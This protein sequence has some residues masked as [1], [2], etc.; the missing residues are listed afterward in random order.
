MKQISILTRVFALFAIIGFF[1]SCDPVEQVDPPVV[2]FGQG[3]D[4]ISSNA[5]VNSKAEF[6]VQVKASK[7]ANPMYTLTI[8][9]D[10][11]K[12]DVSRFTINGSSDNNPKLLFDSDKTS[13]TY[14]ITITA[15][16]SGDAVYDF[17]VNDEGSKSSDKGSFTI[18]IDAQSAAPTISIFG[19]ADVEIE[20]PTIWKMQVDATKGGADLATLAVYED[21]VLVDAG[22]LYYGDLNT[23]FTEN[24][25]TLPEGDVAGFMKD[26]YVKTHNTVE[27]KKYTLKLVD[28]AEAEG[29]ASVNITIKPAATA[30][31]NEWTNVKLYNNSGP[32]FGAIDLETGSNVSSSDA[33]ADIVDLGLSDSNWAKQIKPTSGTDLRALGSG[34][35]LTY[36]S[37]DSKEKLTAAF[38]AGTSLTETGTLVV[39]ST[40]T[41]K[42]NNKLYVFTVASVNETSNDNKDYFEI[43]IKEAQ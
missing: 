18:S 43:N 7:G 25:L 42:V 13:F 40:Y 9:Q 31:T 39:G 2:S 30:L 15:H 8:L 28:K 24:P 17:V 19:S 27:T 16:A 41:A 32:N 6:K 34:E 35:T 11:E 29:T 14:D 37:I 26:I 12:L 10:G 22:R 21:D 20:N 1:A 5:T 36:A 33:S 38:D 3:D 23:T 4:L